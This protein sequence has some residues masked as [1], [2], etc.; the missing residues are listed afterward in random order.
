[1]PLATIS[2]RIDAN[3]K[4]EFDAFCSSV[5]L[6][7][8]TAINLF[9]K[10]VLRERRIPFEIRESSDS[11]YSKPNESYPT[12]DPWASVGQVIGTFPEDFMDERNQ[13]T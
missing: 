4:K 3:D 6:N 5:G 13:P 2:A 10:T 12:Q 8:S 7:A 11:I 1:M 9:I